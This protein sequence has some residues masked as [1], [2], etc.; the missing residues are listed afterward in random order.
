[1]T[2]VCSFI[3]FPGSDFLFTSSLSRRVTPIW[4]TRYSL[5]NLGIQVFEVLVTV[6]DHHNY[7]HN[8]HKH[9]HNFHH[10]LNVCLE[11]ILSFK[12][13]KFWFSIA[14]LAT[15]FG[16][17]LNCDNTDSN[18][19]FVWSECKIVKIIFIMG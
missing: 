3:I 8:Y 9:H 7:H 2:G 4:S 15:I 13:W 17:S 5:I 11:S 16:V 19:W 10:R 6:Q 14:H 1:M 18:S 12:F